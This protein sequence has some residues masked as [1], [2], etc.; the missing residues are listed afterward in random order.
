MIRG[1]TTTA[2][3]MY[4]H[5]YETAEAAKQVGFRLFTGTVALDA[6]D[7]ETAQSLSKNMRAFIDLYKDDSLICPSVQVHG[8]YTVS[9]ETLLIAKLAAQEYGVVFA[10]HASE[11]R[12]EV[13]EMI[14]Q[15]GVTPIEYLNEIGLLNSKTLL[16]HCVHLNG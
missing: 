12:L 16:A 9:K 11:T 4:W 8:T 15:Q 14:A 13:E 7:G 10:T 5:F 6:M 1:G 3:D 2:A